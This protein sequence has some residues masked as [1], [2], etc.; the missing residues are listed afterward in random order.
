MAYSINK[1]GETCTITGIGTCI[2]TNIVIGT[3]IDGYEITAIEDSIFKGCN[4]IDSLTIPFLG[5]TKDVEYVDYLG[6]LFGDT[7]Q[8][9]KFVPE[10]LKT[11]TITGGQGIESYAFYGCNNI[12]KI[13]LPESIRYIDE[14]AFYNCESLTDINI[15]SSV[16]R[17]EDY[18]FY[19]CINLTNIKV[20]NSVT[21]IGP[22][23]FA[24]CPLTS[25]KIPDGVTIIC[26][27]K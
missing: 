20:P 1:D 14:Q 6:Y 7:I 3:Y 22:Y 24:D 16:T 27:N 18:A 26:Y 17:I 8:N 25:I 12:T 11:V 10:S 5:N 4:N 21:R 15:P 23:A 9:P 2:D 13:S 19:E